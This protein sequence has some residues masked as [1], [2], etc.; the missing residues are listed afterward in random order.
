MAEVES[1]EGVLAFEDLAADHVLLQ[2]WGAGGK[3]LTESLALHGFTGD[4]DEQTFVKVCQARAVASGQ[5][6]GGG[7]RAATTAAAFQGRHRRGG[8]GCSRGGWRRRWGVVGRRWVPWQS[9][10][11]GE[12]WAMD[13]GEAC[14]RG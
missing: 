10:R 1:A 7:A 4:I 9:E 14:R 6:S 5:G 2:S 13:G 3:A 8:G 11:G 12:W